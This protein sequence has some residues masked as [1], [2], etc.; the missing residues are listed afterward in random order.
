MITIFF[1]GGGE[2][3]HFGGEASSFNPSN[4][5]DR[6]LPGYARGV[7]VEVSN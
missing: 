7:D 5:L 4:T 6:T 1:L 3:G 2:A